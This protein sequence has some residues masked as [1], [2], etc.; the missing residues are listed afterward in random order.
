MKKFF[1]LVTFFG[2]I[3]PNLVLAQTS[4]QQLPQEFQDLINSDPSI[5]SEVQRAYNTTLDLGSTGVQEQVSFIVSPSVPRPGQLVTAKIESYSSDLNRLQ[6]SWYINDV[7]VKKE[8]GATQHQFTM[9]ELGKVTKVRVVILKSNGQTI[10]KNYSF[11]PAEVDL[12]YESQTFTPPFYEGKANFSRQSTVKVVAVPQVLNK[13]GL[14]VSP[15]NIS[16]T[17]YVDGSVVQNSSGYGKQTFTY[18]S[19]L[20]SSAVKIGVEIST[21]EDGAVANSSITINPV[22]PDVVVYEKSPTLG[23]LYNKA[24][25][26]SFSIK[27][28]EF[29]IEAVPYFFNK[30]L[31]LNKSTLFNWKLNGQTISSPNKNSVVFRND[32]NEE[33]QSDIS[34]S[35]SNTT[36]L[37]KATEGFKLL[38]EKSNPNDFQF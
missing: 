33:G 1:L 12:I 16:Y 3:F 14:Y 24:I 10:D 31:V 21:I 11:R 37:Q 27:I 25:S 38:F 34:V 17:W 7:L 29:E 18:P 36:L 20:L 9:G 23:T 8:I 6:I 4:I 32:K 35:V 5:S 28:P 22:N 15:Q 30:D 2:Y 26:N 13:S 19:K